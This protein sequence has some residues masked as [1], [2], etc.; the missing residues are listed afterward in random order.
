MIRRAQTLLNLQNR[1]RRPLDL[2]ILRAKF[3][4][5][6][7][8]ETNPKKKERNSDLSKKYGGNNYGSTV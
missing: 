8:S 7:S 2:G 6:L 1:E 3:L 5:R 4:E